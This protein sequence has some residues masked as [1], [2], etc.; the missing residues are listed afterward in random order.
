MVNAYLID[1]G[2]TN[3]KIYNYNDVIIDKLILKHE[4]FN[5]EKFLNF[6]KESKLVIYASVKPSIDEKIKNLLQNYNFFIID[7]KI[8]T[9]LKMSK[10]NRAVIGADLLAAASYSYHYFKKELL[11]I[12]LGSANA[13][14]HVDNEANL[15]H[16]LIWPGL[17]TSAKSL[18]ANEL[19]YDIELNNADS[20][21]ADNTSSGINKGIIYAF[22][23]A[24]KHII[25]C[26]QKELGC[27][28]IVCACGGNL[29]FL[30]Q[31]R[32]LIDYT[33]N[34]LIMKGM[35]Y[36]YEFNHPRI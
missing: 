17:F 6:F 8:K 36:L 13:L 16:C 3:I 7:N 15:K 34:D 31:A 2:N 26:Y 29:K 25:E 12:S 1:V 14:I 24:L 23:G 21:L 32:K 30:N 11:L 19:L 4:D 28:I 35:L 22:D 5:E 20:I 27:A 9:N 10:E 33:D 18:F